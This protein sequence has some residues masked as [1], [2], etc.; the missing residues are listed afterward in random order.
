MRLLMFLLAVGILWS[1]QK[2]RAFELKCLDELFSGCEYVDTA[3]LTNYF[4]GTL[5][6]TPIC[7]TDLYVGMGYAAVF[8]VDSPIRLGGPKDS[9]IGV[10]AKSLHIG[11]NFYTEDDIFFDFALVTPSYW[12]D[13]PPQVIIEDYERYYRNHDGYLPIGYDYDFNLYEVLIYIDCPKFDEK[14]AI[15]TYVAF[16]DP[17]RDLLSDTNMIRHFGRE[18]IEKWHVPNYDELRQWDNDQY[19]KWIRVTRFVK[20][21]YDDYI[22]YDLKFNINVNMY[23][24]AG[25]G[26]DGRQ[27]Y[28]TLKG[29]LRVKFQLKK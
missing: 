22:E 14:Y 16:L 2:Q 5:R 3:L 28:G 23:L 8:P 1:C 26:E 7:L 11:T 9:L 15:G 27:Y 12:K 21:E 24:R 19:G 4:V 6:N 13:V 29:D 17:N 10:Y 25:N 20:E 18:Y